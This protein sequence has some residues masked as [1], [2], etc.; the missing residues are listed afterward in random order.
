MVVTIVLP[1]GDRAIEHPRTGFRGDVD[2]V[3]KFDV[4]PAQGGVVETLCDL[5]ETRGH[6]VPPTI[7]GRGIPGSAAEED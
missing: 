7:R 3:V 2:S 6:G 1:T 5:G 4:P